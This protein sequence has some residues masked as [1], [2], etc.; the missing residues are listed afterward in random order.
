MPKILVH[1]LSVSC[2]VFPEIELDLGVNI[3]ELR[4]ISFLYPTCYFDVI[5]VVKIW[6]LVAYGWGDLLW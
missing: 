6:A 3:E 2:L 4:R 1:F 5:V